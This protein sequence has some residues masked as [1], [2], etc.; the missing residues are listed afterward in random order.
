MSKE[1]QN[2]Y[3]VLND[4]G[5]VSICL[6]RNRNVNILNDEVCNQ[7]I[8]AAI[9]ALPDGTTCYIGDDDKLHCVGGS[10][11]TNDYTLLINKPSVEGVTLT[12]AM[13]LDDLNVV[14][15]TTEELE[16]ICI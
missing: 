8:T 13:T 10:G 3:Y 4:D 7:L 1:L 2:V 9:A 6:G 5:T 12:G 16:E 14:A 15:I 11:G